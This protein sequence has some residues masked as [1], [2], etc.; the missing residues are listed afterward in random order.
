MTRRQALILFILTILFFAIGQFGYESLYRLTLYSIRTLA[1]VPLRFYGKFPYWLGDTTFSLIIASIPL[2]VFL[3]SKIL[4]GNKKIL[5]ISILTYSIYLVCCYLIVCYWTGLGFHSLNDFYH[6]EIISKNLRDV[7][8][9][10]TFLIT[11]LLAT[12]LICLTF[13][14]FNLIKWTRRKILGKEKVY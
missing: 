14:L 11:I 6:G 3:I 2:T 5:T 12:I 13:L 1:S 9:N 4:G 10:E 7:N 8:I